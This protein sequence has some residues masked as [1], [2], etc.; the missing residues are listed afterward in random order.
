MSRCATMADDISI[1]KKQIK[2]SPSG[3]WEWT[4]YRDKDG[5]GRARYAGKPWQAH[6][7]LFTLV[8]GPIQEGMFLH[9][10]CLNKSCANPLHLEVVT[11]Q[12][13]TRR[14]LSPHSCNARKSRCDHGHLFD[15]ANTY[16]QGGKRRQCRKCNAA[17]VARYKKRKFWP[18]EH[19]EAA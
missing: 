9:H 11:P 13:N 2:V 15:Y 4:G 6:R 19:Q 3:C 10:L 1:L 7:A 18:L 12:E 17:A 8:V 14:N 5:Y 16:R